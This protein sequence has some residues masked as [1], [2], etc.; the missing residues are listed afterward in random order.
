MRR[1]REDFIG[2][3]CDDIVTLSSVLWQSICSPESTGIFGGG[4]WEMGPREAS[5]RRDG[6]SGGRASLPGLLRVPGPE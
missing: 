2:D 4:R 3:T 1:L 5:D 6:G